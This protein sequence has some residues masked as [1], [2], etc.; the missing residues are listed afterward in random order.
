[1]VIPPY[2]DGGRI[3]EIYINV[4]MLYQFNVQW[5]QMEFDEMWHFVKEKKTKF[6]SSKPLIVAQGEPWPRCS[7]IVILQ[8]SDG[9]MTK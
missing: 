5:S 8:P 2:A 1:M 6:G 3:Y 9:Y 7:A 4:N